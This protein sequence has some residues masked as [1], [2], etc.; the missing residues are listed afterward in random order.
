MHKFNE[1]VVDVAGCGHCG[2]CIVACL[3]DMYADHYQIVY[4]QL[5]KEL[6]YKDLFLTDCVGETF[7]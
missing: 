5:L 6:T 4:Y 2:F 7:Q 1:K 3:R